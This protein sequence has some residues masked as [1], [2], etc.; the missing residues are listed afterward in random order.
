M[1]G[2]NFT[3]EEWNE[4]GKKAAEIAQQEARDLGLPFSYMIG[5]K[6]IWE[7]PDGRKTEVCFNGDG[8]F[9]E[10]PYSGE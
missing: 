1:A 9:T 7:Y 6:L 8:T 5:D 10:T 2:H 4:L 3:P